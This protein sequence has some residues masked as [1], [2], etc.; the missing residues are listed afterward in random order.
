MKLEVF[1]L[2]PSGRRSRVLFEVISTRGKGPRMRILR[3]VVPGWDSDRE[4]N[5]SARSIPVGVRSKV[6]KDGYFLARVNLG[7]NKAKGLKP[8]E[9]ELA[10]EVPPDF[11]PFQEQ[12]PNK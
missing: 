6:G 3:V 2:R 12:P 11:D 1:E 7:A 10:P 9:F 8:T 4:I 5:I